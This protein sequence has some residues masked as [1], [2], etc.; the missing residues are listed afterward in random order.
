MNATWN[1]EIPRAEYF[2]KST[3][4]LDQLIREVTAT[5]KLA[6]DTETTG[7]NKWKDIPLF[8]SLAWG[9][10]RITL[11][12]EVMPLFKEAFDDGEKDWY[13]A[14]AKFDMHMVANFG[15][16][17]AGRTIDI[18]VMHALLHDDRPHG[19]KSIAGEVKGW[20]WSDFK[21]TFRKTDTTTYQDAMMKMF[22][23]NRQMLVE[24]A[25]NDAYATMELGEELNRQLYLEPTWSYYDDIYP[26]LGDVFWKTEAPF[27]RVLWKMERKGIK[28][29]R[30][31][32]HETKTPILK[33]MA[34]IEKRA[35]QLMGTSF[36]I[37]SPKDMAEAL[38]VGEGLKPLGYTSG[39]KSGNR[40]PK[41][42]EDFYLAYR[43]TS[44]LAGLRY[45]YDS[46]RKVKS[47]FIEGMEREMDPHDR[48][49]SSFK[50]DTARCMPA[51]EL[52]LTNRGYIPVEYV[53]V[54]DLVISHTGQRRKVTGT[55][56]H[57]AKPIYT[58][59][60]SNGLRL[61]TTGN[62]EYRS[63]DSWCRAD[64][65]KPGVRLQAHSEVEKWRP[66]PGWSPSQVSSWGRVRNA[67]TGKVRT[68]A[69]KG[70]WG[71]LKVCLSRNGA[72]SR[73]KDRKDFSV[74]RL[75]VRAFGSKRKG[76]VRH[77]NGIA[78]D[79]TVSN[80]GVGTAQEN[81][82]DALKH[83][84]LSQRRAG[85]TKLTEVQVEEIRKTGRPGQPPPKTAKLSFEMAERVRA[86]FLAGEDTASLAKAY[87]V[88][89]TAIDCILK[90]KT[91]TK[92]RP[93]G[94]IGDL[95]R[96]YNVSKGT[97][98][99]IQSG[100]R[101]QDESYITGA[102]VEFFDVQVAHVEVGEPEVTYGLTVEEDHSHVT[103]GI[104]TH[105]TGRLSSKEP[106]LQVIPNADNDDYQLRKMF[107]AD[108]DKLLI[109]RDYNA[110]EMRLLACG[111]M[112]P[113]M[114]AV[115][116]RGWDIHMGNAAMVFGHK[117]EDIAAAK[118]KKDNREPLTDIDKMLIRA[119]GD[120][121]TIGFGG[122]SVQAERKLPQNG[123]PYGQ[124]A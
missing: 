53:V 115:F 118:A 113:D 89:Y 95:A 83:G 92:E 84:T 57:A 51:G 64:N 72:Q 119:R 22:H 52:V 25:A 105:N 19:L 97:I 104:V 77:L 49:H 38:L 9:H 58:V 107:V 90:G 40:K 73:G 34:E 103:G 66:I 82:E 124:A 91:W 10:R 41:M 43:N 88:T 23:E 12:A 69:P 100:R 46:I 75:V 78:W 4:K 116:S 117:Y 50:Q 81:R 68:L 122:P 54:G 30:E 37:G 98:R 120:I 56:V 65:L 114:I 31:R 17:L 108:K 11:H 76:E 123:E 26:T 60:A 5:K 110:L 55:S 6:I 101:W 96:K 79:N 20:K 32:A 109:C 74:H 99:D 35:A 106:A 14:N 59:T 29:D 87:A 27:T 85:R 71:H 18:Q 13:L 102:K 1:V 86:K 94:K 45:E 93:V 36:N 8:W 28:I 42:D 112:E 24:Y 61:R 33:R 121:K 2:D 47:T 111:A 63:R 21:D 67:S 80:L 39:G 3:P 62:H 16:P 70:K 48:V 15:C 44:E 7:L